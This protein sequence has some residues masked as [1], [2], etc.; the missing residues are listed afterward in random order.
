MKSS[1]HAYFKSFFFQKG[2][3]K[4]MDKTIVKKHLHLK[5]DEKRHVAKM[6]DNGASL[7]DVDKW[8]QMR[9][10]KKITKSVYY[11]LKEKC[12]TILAETDGKKKI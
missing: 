9:F 7:G 12:K 4:K 1:R 8:Y 10:G 11:R 6:I 2:S 3:D 5:P